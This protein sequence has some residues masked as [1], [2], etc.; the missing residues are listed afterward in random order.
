[1][2]SPCIAGRGWCGFPQ[3]IAVA[4]LA[5]VCA[6]APAQ[7]EKRVALVVGNGAYLHAN[8]LD[9]PLNRGM[10][11]ALA[12]LEFDA[13]YG[14]NLDRKALQRMIARLAGKSRAPTWRWCTSPATTSRS[15]T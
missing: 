2:V 3:F 15:T 11:D 9:N 5:L 10:H 1:V 4:W 7:A 13:T 14:E 12:A 6:L 8:R